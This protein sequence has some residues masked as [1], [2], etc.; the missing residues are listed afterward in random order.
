MHLKK[1][2]V[3]HLLIYI[4]RKL[5]MGCKLRFKNLW[6]VN[7]GLIVND[8]TYIHYICL[9]FMYLIILYCFII[10]EKLTIK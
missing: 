3:L 1:L 4:I 10:L 5:L 2:L 6:I 9:L 7:K 8:L